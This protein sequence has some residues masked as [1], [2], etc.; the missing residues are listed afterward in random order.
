MPPAMP[1]SARGM[2]LMRWFDVAAC[3]RTLNSAGFAS[4]RPA[5]TD[6]ELTL[7][8]DSPP[9]GSGYKN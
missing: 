1:P 8:V 3:C 5:V 6:P 4:S 7:R 2:R 9:A